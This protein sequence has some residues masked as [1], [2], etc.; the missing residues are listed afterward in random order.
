MEVWISKAKMKAIIIL[1]VAIVI[2]NSQLSKA[3]DSEVFPIS[4]E[5]QIGKI[6]NLLDRAPKGLFLTVG[7]ERA[8]RGASMFDGLEYLIIFDISPIIIRFNQINIELLRA[9]NKET[10]T[11]RW[12]ANFAEWKK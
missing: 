9:P 10:K 2:L 6:K 7:G 3:S 5:M 8:F 12:D 11:L 4:T 1:I